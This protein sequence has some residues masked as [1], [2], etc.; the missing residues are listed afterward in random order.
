ML[1]IINELHHNTG[2][3]VLVLVVLGALW[4]IGN[5]PVLIK[6]YGFLCGWKIS[7]WLEDHI[8]IAEIVWIAFLL[9]VCYIV[10]VL[11]K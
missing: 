8:V 2:M 4:I 1:K 7:G 6:N 5:L 9:L 3:W 10:Y 11:K